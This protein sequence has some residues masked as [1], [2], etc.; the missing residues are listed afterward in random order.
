MS[1]YKVEMLPDTPN[2]DRMF[3]WYPDEVCESNKA[4]HYTG[5]STYKYGGFPDLPS[6]KSPPVT[7]VGKVT[8]KKKKKKTKQ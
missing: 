7:P 5:S 8:K 3:S 1:E 4:H 6:P 2:N